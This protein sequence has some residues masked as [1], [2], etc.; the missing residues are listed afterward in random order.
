[1]S[2]ERRMMMS[3]TDL[4]QRF[5]GVTQVDRRGSQKI[6]ALVEGLG[7]LEN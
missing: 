5:Q 7:L 2:V 4:E 3:V 6:M 1:M